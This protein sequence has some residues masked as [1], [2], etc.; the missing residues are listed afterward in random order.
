MYDKRPHVRTILADVDVIGTYDRF[1]T[2]ST[3]IPIHWRCS[4]TPARIS[5]ACS[6]T[7]AVKTKASVPSVA[8]VIAA[9]FARRR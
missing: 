3:E 6:P 4:Q 7:P 8:A 1:A 2:G 9:I 5:L